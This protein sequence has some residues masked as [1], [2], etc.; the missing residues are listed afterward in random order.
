M[1]VRIGCKNSAMMILKSDGK[2]K[3]WNDE[4]AID[5]IIKIV[6]QAK[7]LFF[8]FTFIEIF[9]I[10]VQSKG[11]ILVEAKFLVQLHLNASFIG[12]ILKLSQ[13]FIRVNFAL[14]RC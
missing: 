13:D 3:I 14:H 10:K 12:G 8:R 1:S 6:D 11:A 2:G 7:G 4:K 9:T 5:K